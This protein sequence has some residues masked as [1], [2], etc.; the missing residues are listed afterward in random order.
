M[1]AAIDR[2]GDNIIFSIAFAVFEVE[3]N[4]NWFRVCQTSEKKIG[5]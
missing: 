5:T 2:D 4:P 3:D 1:V